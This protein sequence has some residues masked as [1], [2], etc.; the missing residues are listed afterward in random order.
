SRDGATS[1]ASMRSS[2]S[3]FEAV[4]QLQPIR[5]HLDTS[6]YA[7][8]YCALPGSPA[9]TVRDFLKRMAALGKIQI[10]LS[11]HVVFELLQKAAPQYREDRLA[12]ARLLVELC[13]KNAFPYP[14]DLGQGDKVS[15]GGLWIP[16]IELE[17]FEVENI[18]DHYADAVARQLNLN[19][20]QRRAFSK[21]RNFVK[22]ARADER[23]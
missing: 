12:R 21:R 22:W 2:G 17:D 1:S 13:G 16:R 11:Y 19:R 5:L 20:P 14:T 18:V 23:R 4:A 15:T 9:A 7:A 8:M 6:D 10:G 3:S